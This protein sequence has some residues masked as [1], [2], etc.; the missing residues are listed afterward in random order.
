MSNR[1]N[2]WEQLLEM[3]N[4]DLE[5]HGYQ[6][7]L[8]TPDDTDDY[9]LHILHGDDCEIYAENYYEDELGDLINDAWAHVRAK[10]KTDKPIPTI[11]DLKSKLDDVLMRS[12]VTMAHDQTLG[13]TKLDQMRWMIFNYITNQYWDNANDNEPL[14]IK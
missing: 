2:N 14:K 5:K 1:I 8:L 4:K 10:I 9:D 3:A 13:A 11:G 12:L 7:N 6:L